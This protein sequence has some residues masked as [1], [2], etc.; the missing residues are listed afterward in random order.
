MSPQ[1]QLIRG[2]GWSHTPS[3]LIIYWILIS[4]PLVFWDTGYI[5]LRPHS[6]PG[7]SLHRPLWVPYALYGSVDYL[8]GWPAWER[9]DGFPLA[10]GIL[11]LIENALY[12]WYLWLVY[13]YGQRSSQP[14]RGAPGLLANAENEGALGR[15]IGH[16]GN[17][18][19]LSGWHAGVAT[20]VAHAAAVM[21]L[22]KTLLYCEI[23]FLFGEHVTIQSYSP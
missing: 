16:L 18:R 21:T 4:V 15:S 7:G 5:L 3:Y 8:Y 1:S 20:L 11:N 17:A 14:G 6:M 12:I 2:G 13:R 10:Q 22:S 9:G 19:V 23:P